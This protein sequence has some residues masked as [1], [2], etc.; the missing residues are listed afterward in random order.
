MTQDPASGSNAVFSTFDWYDAGKMQIDIGYK[1]NNPAYQLYYLSQQLWHAQQH[2][3]ENQPAS[4]YGAS[5]TPSIYVSGTNILDSSLSNIST[6]PRYE[7]DADLVAAEIVLQEG[8]ATNTDWY[9]QIAAILPTAP[10]AWQTTPAEIAARTAFYDAWYDIVSATTLATSLG[11]YQTLI[12][13]YDGLIQNF[14]LGSSYFSSDPTTGANLG[15]YQNM[16]AGSGEV[17]LETMDFSGLMTNANVVGSNSPNYYISGN[18]IGILPWG[19][20]TGLGSGSVTSAFPS[21]DQQL[22]QIYA[23]ALAIGAT[24]SG[25]AGNSDGAGQFDASLNAYGFL[26]AT[27]G[28]T[29]IDPTTVPIPTN[30]DTE[31]EQLYA[32]AQ[33]FANQMAA[34][35]GDSDM[36]AIWG[37]IADDG[38]NFYDGSGGDDGGGDDGGGD[39]GGG[40]GG[41]GSY[42]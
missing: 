30:L 38:Y 23:Q 40:G 24:G 6:S 3:G 1:E 26:P 10:Q 18:L 17:S 5:G 29:N 21:P 12:D 34:D 37:E 42:S 2:I 15:S 20:V 19:M 11:G 9:G 7:I 31:F 16:V 35:Q 8:H 25:T 32:Q 28:V 22:A 14:A 41:G 36:T 39:D 4:Y 13:C 33:Q 27:K